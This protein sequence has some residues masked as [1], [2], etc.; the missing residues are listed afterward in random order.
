MPKQFNLDEFNRILKDHNQCLR[1]EKITGKEIVLSNGVLLTSTRDVRLCKK[2]VMFGDKIWKENFDRV[3]SIDNEVSVD[4][5]KKCR[6]LTSVKGG[7]ICQRK[8]RDQ[9]KKNLNISGGI[10]WNKGLKGNYPYSH[11]HSE[12]T[13]QKISAAN[14]GEKNGMFGTQKSNEEKQSRSKLMKEKILSGK[15]TPNSNNRNTHWNSCYKNK[16]YRSSWEALYQYFDNAAEYETLRIPYVFDNKEHIYIID[17][18][19]YKTRTLVEVKPKELIDD[20]KTQAKIIAAKQWCKDNDYQ[21]ILADQGYFTSRSMPE[22]LSDFD[23][24]TQHKIK[25]LYETC[26]Q[27][28]N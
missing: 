3:Y 2:R 9:I 10:P 13:K 23:L 4:A 11:S 28:R 6:S 20:V 24:N 25:K 26:Q 1:A 18:V 22:N 12:E 7:I 16:K 17:F 27:K 15:F 14:K 19:N 5:E 8:H 21:F